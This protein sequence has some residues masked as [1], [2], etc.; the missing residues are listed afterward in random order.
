M[1]VAPE[2]RG[3]VPFGDAHLG[4]EE[5]PWM[6]TDKCIV[7]KMCNRF[8]RM[9]QMGEQIPEGQEIRMSPMPTGLICH[10][11]GSLHDPEF[12]NVRVEIRWPK[13]P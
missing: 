9:E 3:G 5:I 6:R 1:L 2:S 13:S 10:H 4:P 12:N 11:V 7:I 8:I